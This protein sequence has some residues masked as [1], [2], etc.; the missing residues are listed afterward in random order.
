MCACA[1]A[2]VCALTTL[3]AWTSLFT[4]AHWQEI[5]FCENCQNQKV[6]HWLTITEP[7]SHESVVGIDTRV[8]CRY[9]HSSLL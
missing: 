3:L 8:C 5:E 4:S 2:C 6:S 1:C 7:F 9:R